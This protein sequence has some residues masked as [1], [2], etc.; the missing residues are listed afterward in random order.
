MSSDP[1]QSPPSRPRILGPLLLAGA[2]VLTLA[3]GVVGVGRPKIAKDDP[4]DNLYFYT[5]GLCWKQGRS[6]YDAKIL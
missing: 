5:A 1:A 4:S 6:P 3:T 2:V